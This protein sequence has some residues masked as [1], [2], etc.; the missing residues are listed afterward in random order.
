ML[1][2]A[3]L[4]GAVA[5]ADQDSFKVPSNFEDLGDGVYVLYDAARNTDEILS[6]VKYN[7]HDWKDYTTNDTDNKYVVV[8]DENNTYNYTDGSVDEVGSFKIVEVGGDK[9][10]MNFAKIGS[11]NGFSQTYG[12]LMDFNNLN[13]L[14]AIEK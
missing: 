13:K 5:A 9:F 8:K 7:E 14:K 1:A 10:I 4:I 6:V 3:M 2:T 12:N 11:D